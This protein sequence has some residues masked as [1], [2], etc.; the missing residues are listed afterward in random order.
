[1]GLSPRHC[2]RLQ[3]FQLEGCFYQDGRLDQ[4]CGWNIWALWSGLSR[5]SKSVSS[6]NVPKSTGNRLTCRGLTLILQY[7]FMS[8]WG[9]VPVYIQNWFS[10]IPSESSNRIWNHDQISH[11]CSICLAHTISCESY[12]MTWYF[13][14]ILTP[15]W[16]LIS[17]F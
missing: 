17:D 7:C 3:V 8:G 14:V 9:S 10:T 13:Y 15:I 16:K 12:D 11:T 5:T 6:S 1:M 4:L 2:L